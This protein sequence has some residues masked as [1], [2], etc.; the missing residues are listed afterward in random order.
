MRAKMMYFGSDE[1]DPISQ[2]VV[3]RYKETERVKN[4]P[5]KPITTNL[6]IECPYCHSTDI[7]KITAMSKVGSVALFGIFAM[8]KVSKQWHCNSCGS[9]F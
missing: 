7:K 4:N 9:D 3:G 1:I 8:G 5:G 2:K 6:V